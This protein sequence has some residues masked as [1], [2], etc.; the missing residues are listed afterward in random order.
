MRSRPGSSSHRV[1]QGPRSDALR[2]HRE[3]RRLRVRQEPL[4]R[5][6]ARHVPDGVSEGALPGRVHR[7]S[8]HQRQEQPRQGGHVPERLPVDGD[9]GAAARRQPVDVE[10]R[11]ARGRRASPGSHPVGGQ[12]GCDHLR[13]L[14]GAQRGGGARRTADRRTG[15]ERAVHE[16]PRLRRAGARTGAEQAHDRVAD[17][18]RRLRQPRAHPSRAAHRVRAHHRHHRQ[19]STRAREGRDEPLRR[20]GRR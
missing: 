2:H 7:L 12:P 15:G 20:L 9:Q 18:G 11:R 19:A 14:R 17:Q 3:V 13:T 8:A 6:R 4:V 10:L 16:L 1:R 5:L